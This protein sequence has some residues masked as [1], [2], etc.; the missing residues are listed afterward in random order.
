[1]SELQC[2]CFAAGYLWSFPLSHV[3][4]FLRTYQ[5]LLEALMQEVSHILPHEK[6]IFNVVFK[7]LKASSTTLSFQQKTQNRALLVY[8][9][10]PQAWAGLIIEAEVSTAHTTDKILILIKID[11]DMG[12]NPPQP[13]QS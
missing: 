3:T 8:Q 7:Y 5:L 11:I 10:F 4:L 9:A 12:I 2:P 13:Q 1:M 6:T